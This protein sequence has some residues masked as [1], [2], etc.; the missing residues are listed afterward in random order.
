MLATTMPVRGAT[1]RTARAAL[2]R[3]SEV[4]HWNFTDSDTFGPF[5]WPFSTRRSCV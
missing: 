1:I 4:L 2:L 5:F 3:A